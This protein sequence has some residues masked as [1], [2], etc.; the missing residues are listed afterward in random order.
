[1]VHLWL[2][3]QARRSTRHGQKWPDRGRS[4]LANAS[5]K[6]ATASLSRQCLATARGRQTLLVMVGHGQPKSRG[7]SQ[8]RSAMFGHGQGWPDLGQSWLAMTSQRQAA[9][10]LL[11]QCLA[12]ARGR[13]TLADHGWPLPAKWRAMASPGRQCLATARSSQSMAGHGWTWPA[14]GQARFPPAS[15]NRKKQN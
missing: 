7:H 14:K 10:S 1:M 2:A 9:A 15:G 6:Q 12:T 4:W 5:Q 3:G 13:Q 11:W 8:P